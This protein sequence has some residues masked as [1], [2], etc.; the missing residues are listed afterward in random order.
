[1]KDTST[2]VGGMFCFSKGN[3]KYCP[4]S[5]RKIQKIRDV[6]HGE[7]A[8]KQNENARSILGGDLEWLGEPCH[9][10]EMLTPSRGTLVSIALLQRS[11]TSFNTMPKQMKRTRSFS[12]GTKGTMMQS[13]I[14]L[15]NKL[16]RR[17][18]ERLFD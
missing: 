3:S 18:T 2:W 16:V 15:A 7:P 9:K 12:K 8:T 4:V 11:I 14:S 1:M 10:I 13:S 6:V 5:R 17:F